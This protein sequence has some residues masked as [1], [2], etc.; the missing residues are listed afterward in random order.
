[1]IG[2]K[3]SEYFLQPPQFDISMPNV[4]ES[5]E[6]LSATFETFSQSKLRIKIDDC[7]I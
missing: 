2:N 3:L 6:N 5:S 4:M 7:L 1:M